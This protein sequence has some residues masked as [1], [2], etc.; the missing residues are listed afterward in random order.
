MME[1]ILINILSIMWTK[2]HNFQKNELITMATYMWSINQAIVVN[3]PSDQYP[4]ESCW[5]SNVG[6]LQPS[7]RYRIS[8]GG[9]YIFNYDFNACVMFG[10]PTNEWSHLCNNKRC[11]RPSHLYDEDRRTNLSRT[12]CPGIMYC[13]QTNRI[14][15]LCNHQPKCK[16][17]HFP[18]QGPMTLKNIKN[19]K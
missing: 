13:P 10:N 6:A 17:V 4:I 14:W 9:R 11:E 3:Y 1:D 15:V 7:G 18:I 19:F 2:I 5:E 12:N 8:F 16:H